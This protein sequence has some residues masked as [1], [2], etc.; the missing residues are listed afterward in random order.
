VRKPQ[1]HEPEEATKYIIV[2]NF[3][4]SR[5]IRDG[6]HFKFSR[7]GSS[8]IAMFRLIPQAHGFEKGKGFLV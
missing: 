7:F 6:G 3:A 2:K 4:A 5:K 8:E 1:K